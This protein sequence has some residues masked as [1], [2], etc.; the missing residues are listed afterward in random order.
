MKPYQK[1]P[2]QDCGETLMPIDGEKIAL[3]TPHFYQKLGADYGGLSPYYLRFGVLNR[4]LQAQSYLENERPG[5]R[6]LIFDAYRPVSVQV[7]M[8]EYT[9]NE[10]KKTH[11]RTAE[12]LWEKVYTIWAVPTDNPLTPPPHS[13]GAAV[14]V[15]LVDELGKPLDMGGE[16]D[17]LSDRSLPDYYLDSS[18]P[19]EQNYHRARQLL[20]RIMTGAGFCRHGGEWWHFSYGDQMWAYLAHKPHAIYGKV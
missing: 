1:L 8:V 16:I 12:E 3:V 14:D 15:T 5:W 18:D 2:I 4:L 11:N 10:L 17:E 7:F 13:T 9:F 19:I 6:I 20:C